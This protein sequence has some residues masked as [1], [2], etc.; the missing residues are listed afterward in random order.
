MRRDVLVLCYHAVSPSW[1]APLAV[2]PAALEEQLGLLLRRGYRSTTF[3]EAVTAPGTGRTLA[4][5]FDDAYRS[6]WNLARPVLERLGLP[7]T[8]FVPTAFIGHGTAL[9]WPGVDH[10]LAGPHAHELAPMSW[11]QLS[12][13][14]GAGWEL[15]AHTRTHP[16]LPG[17]DAA[18]V[19][20]E[21]RG[22][23]HDLEERLGG[24]CRSISYPYGDVDRRVVRLARESGYEAGAG[25]SV[26][27]ADEPWLVCPR[28]GVY[29]RDDLQRFTRKVAPPMR[30]LAASRA[31]PLLARAARSVGLD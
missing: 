22:A 12:T 30:R 21:L 25:L 4:V 8:V 2:D 15:G 28:V 27:I 11:A 7:A 13:L 19:L 26:R 24:V 10:W 18:A 29:R 5:T 23:R 14:A 9:R 1:P 3:T 6:I 20:R 16:R 31:W 17:L